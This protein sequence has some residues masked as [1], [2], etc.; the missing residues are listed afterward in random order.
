MGVCYFL[1]LCETE[2]KTRLL[3]DTM[4]VT[5]SSILLGLLIFVL[6]AHQLVR[7][8]VGPQ[9]VKLEM[10]NQHRTVETKSLSAEATPRLER[11]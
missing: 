4:F 1:F 8:E 7:L 11:S 6:F 3:S 10:S 2:S 9:G 5:Q